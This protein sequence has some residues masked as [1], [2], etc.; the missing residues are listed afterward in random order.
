MLVEI[1]LRVFIVYT[2]AMDFE[3]VNELTEHVQDMIHQF[4]EI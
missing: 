1:R 4:E 3:K 2:D